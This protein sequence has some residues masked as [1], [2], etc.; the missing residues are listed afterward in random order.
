MSPEDEILKE[1]V[2][3]RLS[4]LANFVQ[5]PAQH[6]FF[7]PGTVW[8]LASHGAR[9][10]KEAITLCQQ[11]GIYDKKMVS[12]FDSMTSKCVIGAAQTILP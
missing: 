12:L 4:C 5:D 9:S 11:I 8:W 1:D 10:K 6:N 3:Y 7:A 2:E